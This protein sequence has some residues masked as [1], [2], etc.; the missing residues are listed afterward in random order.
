MEGINSFE[1]RKKE[2]ELILVDR[3]L[4]GGF[5]DFAIQISNSKRDIDILFEL[6]GHMDKKIAWRS[7]YIIDMVHDYNPS[8]IAPLIKEI[9]NTTPSVIN[10][11]I[12]RHYCRILAQHDLSELADG[13]L[14]DA[15]FSWLRQEDIP[16]AVKAHCM[17]I[18]YKLCETYPEMIPELKVHLEDLIPHGSKGEVNRAKQILKQ[19]VHLQKK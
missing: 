4:S 9:A 11:S 10:H 16:I 6:N 12:K 8:A 14:V 1:K 7:A 17:M 3:W 15:C 2:I 19:L 18:L 13:N 5:K